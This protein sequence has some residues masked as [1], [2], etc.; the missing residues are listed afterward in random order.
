MLKLI[1]SNDIIDRPIF[2]R[3]RRPPHRV[4]PRPQAKSSSNLRILPHEHLSGSRRPKSH[5]ATNIGDPFHPSC[6]AP[7]LSTD[8]RRLGECA[9][10]LELGGRFHMRALGD[11]ATSVGTS[12]HQGHSAGKV[13]PRQ[14]S[15]DACVLCRR[16]GPDGRSPGSGGVAGHATFFPVPL[17]F[18]PRHFSAQCQSRRL[19]PG[20]MLDRALFNGVWVHHVHATFLAS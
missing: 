18:R 3:S 19:P 1:N 7:V 13:Q 6:S 15:A 4:R 8:V 14:A 9:L 20:G 11:V 17:L 10:V 12:I 5:G 16:R 2:C